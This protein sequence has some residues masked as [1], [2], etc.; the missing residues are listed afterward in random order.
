MNREILLRELE[1]KAV[2]S[3]GP[4]GQHANKTATKVELYFDVGQSEGLS[5]LEK[6]RLLKNLAS[7]LSK[8]HILQLQ[9]EETRSQ[10]KNKEIVTATFLNLIEK[11]VKKPKVRKKTKPTKASKIKRLKQKRKKS[12]LKESRKNPL[13]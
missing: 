13:R 2:R 5:N 10:H 7:R 11:A 12:E 6:E 9:S 4:G 3:G 8:E 1:Y